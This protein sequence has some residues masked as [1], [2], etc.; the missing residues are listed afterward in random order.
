MYSDR[1]LA[2]QVQRHF[3]WLKDSHGLVTSR[4]S[5]DRVELAGN[6]ILLRIVFSTDLPRI[7]FLAKSKDGYLGF[8]VWEFL[9]KRRRAI[10]SACF[11]E[12]PETASISERNE[13]MLSAI[14]CA[15]VSAGR[16][17]LNGDSAWMNEYPGLPERIEVDLDLAPF[18]GPLAV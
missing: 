14:S 3:G 2:I 11:R 16:D 4:A 1:D 7:F 13:S 6:G 8:D 12:I 9:V 18:T 15:L 10:I 17:I 5:H